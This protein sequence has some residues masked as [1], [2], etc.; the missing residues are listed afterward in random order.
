MDFAS[1]H[2]LVGI[3]CNVEMAGIGGLLHDIGKEWRIHREKI[4]RI[5]PDQSAI[6]IF[7]EPDI[8][9]V[10]GGEILEKIGLPQYGEIARTHGLAE[11]LRMTHGIPG[12]FTPKTLC[13]KI[14]AYADFR[15]I[16]TRPTSINQRIECLQGAYESKKSWEKL[17]NLQNAIPRIKDLEREL[18]ELWSKSTYLR[19]YVDD[20]K[21][22]VEN[23]NKN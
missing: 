2:R 1:R 12:D 21:E 3:D 18:M 9:P 15:V 7:D 19:T 17:R 4:V 8:H 20:V 16:N 14:V 22:F 11:E 5:I 6:G 13:Q 23:Q 10:I